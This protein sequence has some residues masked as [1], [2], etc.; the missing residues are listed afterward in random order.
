ML[1]SDLFREILISP[2][3]AKSD[4]IK[5]VSG[6]ATA[7]M[8]DR[9]MSHLSKLE[10]PIHIDLIVGMTPISGIELT[11]HMGFQKIARNAPYEGMSFNCRYVANSIPVHSKVYCWMKG[12]ALLEAW[13]GSANYTMTGFSRAQLESMAQTDPEY[14]K[15]LY[16]RAEGNS[17]NCLSEDVEDRVIFKESHLPLLSAPQKAT[18][19]KQLGQESVIMSFLVKGNTPARSG[20]N[21]GQRPGR[22]MN[23]AYISIPTQIRKSDFF[24][25]RAEQFTVLTDD[26]DSF[27]MVRAQQGE[28]ALHT[29]PSNALLGKYIRARLGVNSGQYVTREHFV[30]YGRT[31]VSFTKIDEET[32]FMD[33]S[34]NFGPG[35][36]SELWED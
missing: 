5:I 21:W 14:A 28:K 19:Q 7:N 29:T 23:Q 3:T 10:L 30:K 11:H 32:Y 4:R 27:I 20:I 22:D 26:G 24:P 15:N 6:F 33:F 16:H 12:D 8:V 25:D 17:I 18:S 13:L 34:P 1:D 9:H 35:D 36:D 31:D 2:A